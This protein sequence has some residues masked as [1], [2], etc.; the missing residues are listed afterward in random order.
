MGAPVMC[1]T[2]ARL[3]GAGLC[4]CAP[5]LPCPTAPPYRERV[6]RGGAVE[7][8][9]VGQIPLRCVRPSRYY[10]KSSGIGERA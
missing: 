7:R 6:G 9:K 5:E 1:P 8:M 3:G 2:C 10:V 4:S